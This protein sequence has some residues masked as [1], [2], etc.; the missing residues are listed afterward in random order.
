MVS[1]HMMKEVPLYHGLAKGKSLFNR[2]CIVVMLE[3]LDKV[4]T[5]EA[6]FVRLP[7]VL[8]I[9]DDY[10]SS[11]LLENVLHI[12]FRVLFSVFLL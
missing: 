10:V 3:P 9:L 5:K 7:M 2:F 12:L 4:F 8:S 6:L 1:L 11:H